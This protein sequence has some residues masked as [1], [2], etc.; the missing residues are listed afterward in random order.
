MEGVKRK[1]RKVDR[2][3]PGGSSDEEVQ[4]RRR[5]TQAPV[6]IDDSE[7]ED[8]DEDEK[9]NDDDNFADKIKGLL[10]TKKVPADKK[11]LLSKTGE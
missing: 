5:K 2:Y 7:N 11:T 9:E 6:I 1:R 3:V 10:S 8:E 4:T